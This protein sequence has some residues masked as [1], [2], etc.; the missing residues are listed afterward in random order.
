MICPVLGSVPGCRVGQA[1]RRVV[2]GLGIVCDRVICNEVPSHDASRSDSRE[3]VNPAKCQA[4]AV[5]ATPDTRVAGAATGGTG[6]AGQHQALSIPSLQPIPDTLLMGTA[7][8]GG[9][10][11][12]R[13]PE[14]QGENT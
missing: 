11:S 13:R 14:S 4:S 1:A 3:R 2:I 7:A 5:S 9:C 10:L 12:G 8:L 6:V